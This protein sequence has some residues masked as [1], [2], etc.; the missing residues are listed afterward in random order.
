[1]KIV[2]SRKGFDSSAGGGPSPIVAGRTRSL[3]IPEAGRS[4][5]RYCDLGLGELAHAASHKKIAPDA[6]CHEDPMFDQD[7]CW[8]GQCG[9]AQTHL[10]NQGVRAGDVFL[11][12]GLYRDPET[13]HL[14]HRIFG[15]LQVA[16]V[17]FVSELRLDRS[18]RKPRHPHPHFGSNYGYSNNAIWFGPGATSAPAIEGLRLTAGDVT[19]RPSLW[20]RPDWM[21]IGSLSYHSAEWRWKAGNLLQTVGRGQ[22]FVCDIGDRQEP[23]DWLIERIAEIA[24]S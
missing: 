9:P 7:W 14:H 22:E 17:G 1:V 11:F 2:F 19:D 13:G 16:G 8:F 24:G 12:F 23:R 10:L 21:E 18:W 3:P 15:Y 6:W 5:R 20:L 4:P